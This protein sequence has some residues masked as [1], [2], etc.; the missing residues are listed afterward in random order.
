VALSPLDLNALALD[1]TTG[2]VPEALKRRIDLG[3]EGEAG[4][5]LIRGDAA[6][7]RELLDN[8]VDNAVRYSCEGG[9]ATVRVSAAPPTLEISDDGP[10]IPPEERERVFDRF[11]RGDSAAEGGSGLGLAIVR[12]IAERHGGRVELLDAPG[13]RGLLARVFIPVSPAAGS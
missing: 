5:V 12:R 11:Y 13:G 4:P 8:L 1:V 2:W 7:L 9:R 3:F 6:R 10:R